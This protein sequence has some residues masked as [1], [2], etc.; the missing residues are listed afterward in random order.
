MFLCSAWPVNGGYVPDYNDDD[1]KTSFDILLT[2]HEDGS[3]KFWDCSKVNLTPLL[4]VKTAP[5]FG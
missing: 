3:V 4:Q 2:G 5:L 1:N